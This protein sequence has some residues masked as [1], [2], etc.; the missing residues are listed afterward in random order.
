M[1]TFCVTKPLHYGEILP[2]WFL[3]KATQSD[4]VGNPPDYLKWEKDSW[5]LCRFSDPEFVWLITPIR[6]PWFDLTDEVID[7]KKYTNQ[8]DEFDNKLLEFEKCVHSDPIIGYM[9]VESAK[10]CGY[11]IEKYGT[12][13]TNWLFHHLA[14]WIE[15][16][17]P[18]PE[19]EF[20]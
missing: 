1:C 3:C 5:A 4:T 7:E 9:L 19:N 15:T 11:S 2:G 8:C 6:D 20:H 10:K 12:R 16:H 14:V 13:F 18:K 17:E